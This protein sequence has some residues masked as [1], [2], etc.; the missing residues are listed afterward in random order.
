MPSNSREAITESNVEAS[1]AGSVADA[2]VE[3]RKPLVSLVVPAYNEASILEANLQRLCDYMGS[4]EDQYRWEMV[5]INDGSSDDTGEIAEDFARTRPEIRVYH[6]VRNFG[7]GQA[8]KHAF[9][10]CRGDYVVTIDVDLSYAPE[11][12]GLLLDRIRK[13]K[14][15]IVLASPYME[16]GS[17]S[18]V[19]RM[20]RLLS[21]WANR[22][23]SL[24]A[25]GHLST[26]TCM[27]RAYDGEFIRSLNLRAMGM[28]VMPETIYKSMI[29][30]GTIDQIPAHLD[31][32]FRATPAVQRRSSM[33]VLSHTLA[34]VL[35]GFLFRPFM[36]FIVPGLL[37]LIFAVWTNIWMVV[38]F[39]EA[40]GS[41]GDAVVP[42]RISAAVLQ[43]YTDYPHTFIVGLLSLM[44]AIQLISLGILA[45]Q[46]K[47]YFEEIFH[48]GSTIHKS[49]LSEDRG[50][51]D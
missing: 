25:H 45:L 2:P 16:G 19:P 49:R 22:F 5:F 30:R 17:I 23:L 29:M 32:S 12:I 43:A 1:G 3:P 40:Y 6:H 7:L 14:A 10:K 20:R 44:L 33:K 34:T 15:K 31:W 11:H 47:N 21:V 42:D 38:H 37:L 48:L 27:V 26:L 46:S 18:N 28:E 4:L 24:L 39:F 8:F 9:T 13:T 50:R 36:F 41:L 51:E 35:S